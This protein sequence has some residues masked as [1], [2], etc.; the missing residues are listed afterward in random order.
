MGA[1]TAGHSACPHHPPHARHSD[2]DKKQPT[3]RGAEPAE[4]VPEQKGL[5]GK[6][7]TR[8]YKSNYRALRLIM[9]QLMVHISL[10]FK[11]CLVQN[12]LSCN[13][14]TLLIVQLSQFLL[15]VQFLSAK[16]AALLIGGPV[17]ILHYLDTSFVASK[18]K[19]IVFLPFWYGVR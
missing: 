16:T 17:L 1:P 2:G 11:I 3:L 19:Y 13:K 5:V 12:G 8:D 7:E 4:V 9:R 6:I 10:Q 14:I 15:L 18:S